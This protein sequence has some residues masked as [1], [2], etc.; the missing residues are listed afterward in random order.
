M[1][2]LE[3]IRKNIDGSWYYKCN[4]CRKWK[5]ESEF[6]CDKHNTVRHGHTSR[7]KECLHLVNH[8]DKGY[9]SFR[10][11]AMKDGKLYCPGCD[12]YK[13][14]EE[15]GI[16]NK[17]TSRGGRDCRCKDCINKRNEKYFKALNEDQDK[18]LDKMLK[19]R[20]FAAKRRA[21]K[22]GFEFDIT[23]EFLHELWDK[24]KGLCSITKLPMTN[25]FKMD[26]FNYNVSVDRIDSSKGYTKDNVQ[27]VCNIVNRMKLDLSMRE[28]VKLCKIIV[29]E[30]SN[31]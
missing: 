31:I 8:Y 1:K 23:I 5:L 4:M 14:P 9:K 7:C 29:D 19:T 2:N 27:L 18:A 16:M 11:P 28:L 25:N 20:F 26:Q 17:N 13:D 10:I 24:Q 30:R 15:F 22:K 12:Q 21:E 6:G 3:E